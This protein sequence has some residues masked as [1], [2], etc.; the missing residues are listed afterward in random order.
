MSTEENQEAL[1][2]QTSDDKGYPVEERVASAAALHA[3]YKKF[4]DAD[5]ADGEAFRR[6]MLSGMINGNPPHDPDEMEAEG[7]GALTNVNF[8]TMRASLD[9]RAASSH[10]LFFEVPQLIE[11]RPNHVVGQDYGDVY[12]YA[13]VV[14]E[15]FTETLRKWS[16]FHAFMDR[17]FR[18]SDAYGIGYV[19]WPSRYDWKFGSFLRG[20][21]I[22]NPRASVSVDE[23]SIVLSRATMEAGELFR[24]ASKEK[25]STLAGWNVE[26]LRKV[27]IE[28]FKTG[29]NGEDQTEAFQISAWESLVQRHRH[30]DATFIA[31]EFD[32]VRVVHAFVKEVSGEQTITH[33]I[34]PEG[35]SCGE[36]EFMFKKKDSYDR[37][38]EVLWWLPYNYG[39]GY[40][41]SVR[42]VAS[43]MAPH[44]DLSNRFLCRVF[45]A[46]QLSSSLILQPVGDMT[47]RDLEM[48]QIGNV[49]VLPSGMQAVQTS[50]S[51]NLSP[52][53]QLRYVS[54]NILKNNIGSYRQHNEGFEREAAKTARQV[55]EESSKEARYEK[56]AVN[57]RYSQLDRLYYELLRRLLSPNTRK[58]D[59]SPKSSKESSELFIRRCL[60]RGVPE[61]V[62]EN[63]LDMYNVAATRAIGLG[64]TAVKYDITS[65]IMAAR[66]MLDEEGRKNAIYDY[67]LARVGPRNVDRYVAPTNRDLIAGNDH[68][69]AMLESNDLAEGQTVVVGGDQNHKIHVDVKLQILIQLMQGIREQT[70]EV[71]P[72][73]VL[74]HIHGLILHISEHLQYMAQDEQ[75]EAYIEEAQSILSDASDL[76][77]DLA[78]QLQQAEE[79]QLQVREAQAQAQADQ[80]RNELSEENQVKMA[81]IQSDAEMEAM[82]QQSLNEM[83]RI[84]TEEQMSIQRERAAADAR[85][86]RDR[87]EAEIAMANRKLEVELQQMAAKSQGE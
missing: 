17:V 13:A 56:S 18:E 1:E 70:L 31:R 37:M 41:R 26:Y 33:L 2:Y 55:I 73:Q 74:T 43:M 14:A 36:E 24:I 51:P 53:I 86:K 81:E 68:S 82:K 83:R 21:L 62:L 80:L 78:E 45:D 16:E 10:E 85:L 5:D 29:D 57:F 19:M 4:K 22:I 15:E 34:I 61:E 11:C 66:G 79:A 63:F 49:T 40:L 50:F 28:V 38:S 42:G 48:T 32:D 9:A 52:L 30:N 64:S 25:A 46:A 6:S 59:L 39:D 84:K 67:V 47:A 54:E 3:I 12:T 76:Y 44:D 71:D 60:D 23:N 77:K 7:L 72:R 65:Q 35:I 69:I 20:N 8:M 27:L 87:M 75:R 58:A